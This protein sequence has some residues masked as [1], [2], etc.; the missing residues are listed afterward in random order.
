[1]K[2]L[3]IVTTLA[4]CTTGAI[5]LGANG[6]AAVTE[7]WPQWRGP[8]LDGTTGETDIPETWGMGSNIAWELDIA[9]SW[10]G[11]TP[12]IWEDTIFLNVSY[13]Q[14]AAERR[15]RGR[16][17]SS[18]PGSTGGPRIE[19]GPSARGTSASA[20]T[21]SPLIIESRSTSSPSSVT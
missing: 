6:G 13:V 2:K 18:D 7:N 9:D 8:N 5:A 17:G 11:A 12:I 16:G 20:L 15:G 3:L 10:T 1:V 19:G 4:L 21:V 14:R